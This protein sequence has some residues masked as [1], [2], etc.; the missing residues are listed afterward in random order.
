MNWTAKTRVGGATTV[1]PTKPGVTSSGSATAPAANTRISNGLKEFLL[2]LEDVKNPRILDLGQV[3]QATLTFFIEKGYK[4]TTEDSLRSWKEFL[5]AEEEGLRLAPV[6]NGGQKISQAFLAEK[7]LE[8]GLRYAEESFH[9]V[10]AWD[11][12]DYFDAELLPRAMERLYSLL[13]P[14]GVVLAMFHSKPAERFHRYRI[15]DTQTIEVLPA[16]TLAV[17]AHVFQN[18]EILDLFG[19]FRSSKTFVGRDQLREALFLK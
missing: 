11:L 4:V 16:A 9:G 13:Q 12:L 19:K 17:H 6:G 10:L 3:S 7:F 1:A 8:S 2:H 14:S 15:V 5:S 18:R